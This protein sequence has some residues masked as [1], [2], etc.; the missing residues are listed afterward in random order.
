MFGVCIFTLI[1]THY[2]FSK[3]LNR[4]IKQIWSHMH[5]FIFQ[6]DGVKYFAPCTQYEKEA[7]RN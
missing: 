5:T 3:I 6:K 1:T 4:V 2:Q 7:I